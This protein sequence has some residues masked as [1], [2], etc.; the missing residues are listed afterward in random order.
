MNKEE[1]RFELLDHWLLWYGGFNATQIGEALGI[2]RQNVSLLI[3]HYK[4]S[5]PEGTLK[6]DPSRKMHVPG[7]EFEAKKHMKK[8]H[9]FLDHLRGQEL[10]NMYRPM[11]WWDPEDEILFENLDPLLLPVARRAE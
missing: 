11:R 5:R 4:E 9:L 1:E 10:I 8:S 3:R 7:E 6:Y 2:S